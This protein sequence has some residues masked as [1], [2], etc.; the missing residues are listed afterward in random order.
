MAHFY[1]M[2][3]WVCFFILFY[4]YAGYPLILMALRRGNGEAMALPDHQVKPSITL[5][6]PARNEAKSIARK[7]ENTLDLDYPR[8]LMEIMVVSDESTDGTDDIVGGFGGQGIRL[9]V[10]PVRKGKTAAQNAAVKEAHGEIIVFSDAN[11]LYQKDALNRLVEP[12]YDP[13]VSCVSGQLKYI[14]RQG[15]SAGQNEN[16][17]WWYEKSIKRLE[18]S[19]AGILGAN[20]S[21][22]AVRKSDYVPL[23]SDIISDF[24]E[25]LVIAGKGK[26]VIYAPAAVS[27][28]EAS[29]S[30]DEEFTRKRRIVARSLYGLTRHRWLLNPLR[31]TGIAFGL[32]S[33]KLLR[34]FS[35]IFLLAMFASNICVV[36]KPFYAGMFWIQIVFYVFAGIGFFQ[37]NRKY[38]T[39]LLFVPFY[40]SVIWY[41]S[42]LGMIDWIGG[43]THAVWEPSRQP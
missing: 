9:L 5:I 26:H 33:H 17:Y 25:P 13:D 38:R 15:N 14:T 35:P 41:A 22:Y 42:L 10:L 4:V 34:W 32:I 3:F 23:E 31:H 8:K 21:I 39:G 30:F 2:T 18:N 16:L 36:I 6:I 1:E 24:I 11:A 43:R 19:N 20:G 27:Y 28:E 12:F 7:L 37:R 40:I 29:G